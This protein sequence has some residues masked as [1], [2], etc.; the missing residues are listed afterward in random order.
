MNTEQVSEFTRVIGLIGDFKP[1]ALY[2]DDEVVVFTKDCPHWEQQ[3]N[4]WLNVFWENHRPWYA[5]WKRCVG[6]S[7]Y[8]PSVRGLRGRSSVTAV[9]DRIYR[10]AKTKGI[11]GKY[12][13]LLRRQAKGLTVLIPA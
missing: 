7:I 13:Q 11:F 2:F 3:V 9:L 10:T 8:C 1:A 5:P 12:N 4:P 6:F